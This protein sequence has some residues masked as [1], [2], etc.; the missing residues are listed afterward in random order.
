MSIQLT[1]FS[2]RL[3][4]HRKHTRR[5]LLMALCLFLICHY[6]AMAQAQTKKTESNE[7]TDKNLAPVYDLDSNKYNIIKIGKQYWFRENLRTTKYNDSSSIA[8]GLSNT[9]WSQTKAGAYA[10]YDNNPLYE[11]MYGKL[12]NGYA[13]N[14]GRLCP[15]NWR[16][17]T[18]KDWN[19]LELLLGVPASELERT[20][21]RGN[22]ADKLKAKGNWNESA[23][24][25]SNESGFSLQPGGARLDNGEYGNMGQYGNFWT[26]TVYDDRYGLLYLWNHHTH[27]N[28]NAVGRIYTKANNGYSCRCVKDIKAPAKK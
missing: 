26:S 10:V 23:Y 4:Q 6:A 22:M 25:A 17:A 11:A 20:G 28:S 2:F 14:S 16:V 15:K 7:G 13:V 19:E 12:Y 18:D 1:T 21:E 8:T 3:A 24:S 9:E 5:A 27:Y